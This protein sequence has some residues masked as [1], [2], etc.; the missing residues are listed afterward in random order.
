VASADDDGV[1]KRVGTAGHAAD[2]WS[3]QEK[4]PVEETN[5]SP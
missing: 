4:T 3:K 2:H 5:E 1:V